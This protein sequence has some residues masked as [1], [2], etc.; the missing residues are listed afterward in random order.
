MPGIMGAPLHWLGASPVLAYNV[1]L[2]LGFT[3]TAW[4]MFALVYE[5]TRDRSAA[6]VAASIFAFNTHTLDEADPRAGH[7]RVGPATGVALDGSTDRR[8]D[9]CVMRCGSLCG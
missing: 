4:A 1:V 3:L 8:Q 7:P 6:L 9:D 5:W 2:L